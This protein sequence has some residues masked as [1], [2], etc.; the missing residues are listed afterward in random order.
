M[1]VGEEVVVVVVVVEG[2]GE[3]NVVKMW[4]PF[5]IVL[6]INISP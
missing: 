1:S 3:G 6:R 5:E 2:M 4:L